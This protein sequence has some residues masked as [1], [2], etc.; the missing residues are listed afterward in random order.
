MIQGGDPTGTGRGGPGYRFADEFVKELTHDGPGVLSMANAGPGTNGSQFFITHKATPWLDGKHT[1]FG[2]VV[3]G[4]DVVDKI[5]QGDKIKTLTIIRVGEEAEA[6]KT[7]QAAFDGELKKIEDKK[8]KAQETIRTD[9]ENEMK[10]RYPKAQSLPSGL[11]FEVVEKGSGDK[12]AKGAMVAVHYKG[13]FKDGKVF[14]SSLDRGQPIEFKVGTGQ[15][16]PGWDEALLDMTKGEKRILMIPYWL[17]YG[18]RGYP[19]AIPPKSD[20]IFDVQLMDIK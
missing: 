10:Q 8:N 9:F 19:G 7:D 1:V 12:P 6:F 13:M 14:D 2:R 4:Q 3:E 16:I 20:L 15:V 18:E 5:A 17:A 11:M